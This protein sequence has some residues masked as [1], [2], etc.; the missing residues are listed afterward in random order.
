MKMLGGAMCEP[1]ELRGTRDETRFLVHGKEVCRVKKNRAETWSTS[2]A[3][4]L[5][6]EKVWASYE[7][8]ARSALGFCLGVEVDEGQ[9]ED[10]L[11][12]LRR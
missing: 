7:E 11:A 2:F 4:G 3:N 9:L 1:V 8:A 5:F 6:G 10:A 12:K